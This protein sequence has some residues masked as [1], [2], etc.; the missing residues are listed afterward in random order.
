ML[1]PK[2]MTLSPVRRRGEQNQQEQ[3][4]D[5]EEEEINP[6]QLSSDYAKY[7]EDN[8]MKINEFVRL[9]NKDVFEKILKEKGNSEFSKFVKPDKTIKTK[10]ESKLKKDLTKLN[11]SNEENDDVDP[12]VKRENQEIKEDTD[13]LIDENK[14][15]IV[16]LYINISYF[17]IVN[18]I[19]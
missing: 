10:D 2:E 8:L 17:N 18:K 6:K 5:K 16:S 3:V 7:L 4:K 15:A 9:N 13:A 1:N 19:E 12:V 11:Q 14:A